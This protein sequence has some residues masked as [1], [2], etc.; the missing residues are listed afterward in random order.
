MFNLRVPLCCFLLLQ[1]VWVFAE[2]PL[3]QQYPLSAEGT[4]KVFMGREIAH[5]MGYQGAAWLEREA[6]EKEERTDVLVASLNLQKGMKVA[7]VGAGTGYLSR[8]MAGK[9]GASG[10]VYALDVQPEMVGKIK[11]LAKKYPNIQPV[12][13]QEQ[14]VQLPENSVDL[15]MMVDVY[16]ELAYPHEM[17]Q[18]V[19]RALKPN[20]QLVL[21]EYR[22]E[23]D[24]VPI[25]QTH[26]MS[27]QQ[28]IKELTVH[29]LKWQKTVRNLPWQHI[30]IFTKS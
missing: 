30:V 22:A 1:A 10:L 23:D 25:K 16:H 11:A 4:G 6:R 20:A 15:A 19:L 9:V 18:S 28:I 24:R 13:S 5:V 12:L 3:Y 27:E 29:P 14:D 2:A 17:I 7:D 21:V 26:R 8:R